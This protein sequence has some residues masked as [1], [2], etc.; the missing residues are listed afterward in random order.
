MKNG[1]EYCAQR[2]TLAHCEEIISLDEHVTGSRTRAGLIRQGIASGLA[3][4]ITIKEEIVAFSLL[5][6]HF[7]GRYFLEL[8]IVKQEHRR[9]GFGVGLLRDVQEQFGQETLFTSTNASNLPMQRL[10]ERCGFERCGWI[11]QLDENDPEIVYCYKL[12]VCS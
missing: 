6:K 5:N 3:Y 2:A 7:Y 11:S 8:L 9:K 1:K 12:H 4:I 10:L